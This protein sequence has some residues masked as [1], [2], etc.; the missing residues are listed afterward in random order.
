L[1]RHIRRRP[2]PVALVPGVS[3][4]GSGDFVN[5]PAASL[6]SRER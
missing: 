4:I 2:A 5:R 6:V 3:N 1:Q